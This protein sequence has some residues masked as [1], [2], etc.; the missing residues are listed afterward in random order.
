MS[1]PLVSEMIGLYLSGR[2]TR[3]EIRPDSAHRKGHGLAWLARATGDCP[4]A[5]LDRRS[6]EQFMEATRITRG[7]PAVCAT[8]LS[9]A[10]ATEL[11]PGRS[12]SRTRSGL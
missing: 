12:C 10:S 11:W 9:S 3:G 1:G 4:V 2:V 5:K 7:P 6:A 8:P